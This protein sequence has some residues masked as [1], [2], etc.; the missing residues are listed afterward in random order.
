MNWE[1]ILLGALPFSALF[2]L[3]IISPLVFDKDAKLPLCEHGYA[4][5]SLCIDCSEYYAKYSKYEYDKYIAD[6]VNDAYRSRFNEE[7]IKENDNRIKNDSNDSNF[8]E[9]GF[10]KNGEP[11]W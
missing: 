10:D 5:K 8:E 7:L 11:I 2:I 4:N 1:I 9:E 6:K 3:F